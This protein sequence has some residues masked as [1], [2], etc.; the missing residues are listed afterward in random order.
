MKEA[1][2]F[3]DQWPREMVTTALERGADALVVPSFGEAEPPAALLALVKTT[4]AATA[5][6]TATI[7]SIRPAG[8]GDRVRIDT[9]SLTADGEGVLVGNSSSLLFL[10][11]AEVKEGEQVLVTV[12][13]AGRHFGIQVRETIQEK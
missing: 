7:E 11:Q 2:V 8:P 3:L 1:W 4:V 5:L 9:C 13:H 6:E 12:E 10:I